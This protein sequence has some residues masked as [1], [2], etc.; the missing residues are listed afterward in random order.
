MTNGTV[1]VASPSAIGRHPDASGSSVPAW[2]A[3]RAD[4]SRRTA[5]TAWVEVMPTAL[6]STTQPWM[7]SFG[8]RRWPAG[9]S[10]RWAST[11]AIIAS[12]E[13][14][15]DR[16]RAQQLLDPLRL[17]EPLVEPEPDV[18]REFQIDLAG[19]DAGRLGSVAFERG[20]ARLLVAPAQRHHVD[21]REPQVGTHADFR[22]RDHV[23]FEHGIVHLALGQHLGE[24]MA[25]RLAHAQLALRRAGGG[26]TMLSAR[27]ET[28]TVDPA[29]VNDAVFSRR[30]R[31]NGLLINTQRRLQRALHRLDAIAFDDVALADRK[32]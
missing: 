5:E 21:G 20:D 16:R 22:H 13:V 24:R 17:V 8:R 11:L 32:S 27:H 31:H 15:L 3:R 6:S 7:S 9:S 12:G 14:A 10:G 1:L 26:F 30:R 23:A 19:N 28:S 2:P 29:A 18:G 25:H 4:V